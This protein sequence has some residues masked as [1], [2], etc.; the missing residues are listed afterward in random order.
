[1][2]SNPELMDTREFELPAEQRAEPPSSV[3][4]RLRADLFGLSDRGKVRANNEDRVL[5]ASFGR[6][7]HTIAG[8]LTPGVL[9][10]HNDARGYG[11]VVA[12][13]M[14]G[15]AAGEIASTLA[16]QTLVQLTLEAPDWILNPTDEAALQEV[17]R[18]TREFVDYI[19]KTLAQQAQRDTSLRGFG[20]TM[21]LAFTLGRHLFITQIGDSRAYLYR[22]G[23]LHRL[24]RDHTLAQSLA[25]RGLI[26]PDEVPKHRLRHVLTNVLCS[27]VPAVYAD[28][29]CFP[30]EQDDRLLLCTDGLTEMISDGMITELLRLEICSESLCRRLIDA[31]LA[32]GATDNVTVAVARFDSATMET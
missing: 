13:G 24:T 12:D 23:H 30:L 17:M 7:L 4:P 15:C 16:I 22:K 31:A 32:A 27:N 10:Q 2:S 29:E 19:H 11:L 26:T 28:V 20:T 14:G 25:D 9:P 21:T 8:N 6:F 1:M 18:R 3:T 5:V